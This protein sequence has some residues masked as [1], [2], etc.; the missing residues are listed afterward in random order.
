M[1]TAYNWFAAMTNKS[2]AAFTGG[3]R[4]DLSVD[5]K[6]ALKKTGVNAKASSDRLLSG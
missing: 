2:R 6:N 5:N 3:Q 4:S 1:L